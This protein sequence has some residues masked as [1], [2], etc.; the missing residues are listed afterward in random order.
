MGRNRRESLVECWGT[1]AETECGRSNTVTARASRWQANAATSPTVVLRALASSAERSAHA[2]MRAKPP[3]SG[4]SVREAALDQSEANSEMTLGEQQQSSENNE[5]QPRVGS[6]GASMPRQ[7][8]QHCR[9]NGAWRPAPGPWWRRQDCRSLRRRRDRRAP[10]HVSRGD[11][12][13]PRVRPARRRPGRCAK[14]RGR[15]PRFS[16]RGR[17]LRRR[18]AGWLQPKQAAVERSHEQPVRK[19]RRRALRRSSPFPPWF[20]TLPCSG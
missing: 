10:E 8:Y 4:T 11:R 17:R 14:P 2:C 7:W 19:Q 5:A 12:S 18:A 13:R 9:R 20:A 1:A 6:Q 15:E 16:E 3:C